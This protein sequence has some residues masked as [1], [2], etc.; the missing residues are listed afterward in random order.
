MDCRAID[1]GPCD[2]RCGVAI[3]MCTRLVSLSGD[4]SAVEYVNDIKVS[5]YNDPADI[6]TT[7][8]SWF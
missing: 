4:I 1:Y 3:Y 6:V 2:A 5:E 7:V 8:E